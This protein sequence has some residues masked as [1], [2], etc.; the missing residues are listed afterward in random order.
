MKIPV[1]ALASVLCLFG[2]AAHA[3]ELRPGLWEVSSNKMQVD[4]QDLPGMQEMLAQMK[5][6]PPE[7]RK[8]MEDMLAKQGVALG[9][10]GVRVCL[11]EAQV[12]ARRLPMADA[13]SGCT[14]EFT[15]QS[16]DLWKF[17]FD[18]PNGKGE[19]ETRLL[20]DQEFVTTLNTQYSG[21]G[22]SQSGRMESHGR[23]VSADCGTLKPAQQ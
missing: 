6:M 22:Q 18:C 1:I 2:G 7:Q 8:M 9:D 3:T 10:K 13:Q 11:S 16:S 23:W 15:E 19:G 12:K 20:S 5:N 14:H 17:R 21:Q 4:G